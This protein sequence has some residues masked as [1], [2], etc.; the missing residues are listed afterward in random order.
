MDQDRS[1]LLLIQSPC[2]GTDIDLSGT[3]LLNLAA[4][5]SVEVVT[6]TE[7]NLRF[8]ADH[9]VN[10]HDLLATQILRYLLDHATYPNGKPFIGES[11][12]LAA[13]EGLP[14]EA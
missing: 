5:R 14:L 6:A 4:I 10:V 11:P 12:V 3:Q 13:T 7:L 8:S 9:V 2:S 1:W